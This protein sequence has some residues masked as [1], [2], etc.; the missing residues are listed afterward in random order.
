VKEVANT[1][2]IVQ[3]SDCLSLPHLFATRL[4]RQSYYVYPFAVSALE[5][6]SLWDQIYGLRDRIIAYLQAHPRAYRGAFSIWACLSP[7]WW[8]GV[9]SS[10]VWLYIGGCSQLGPFCRD[11]RL[12]PGCASIESAD[13]RED[14]ILLGVY[15]PTTQAMHLSMPV[16]LIFLPT[17]DNLDQRDAGPWALTGIR[18]TRVGAWLTDFTH[19]LLC[20]RTFRDREDIEGGIGD[21]V[22]IVFDRLSTPLIHKLGVLRERVDMGADLVQD[23]LKYGKCVADIERYLAQAELAYGDILV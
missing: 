17:Y 22:T 8:I 19:D 7:K 18:A 21:S 16:H 23:F 13:P 4:D 6:A 20:S 1:V 12:W 11:L 15:D 10:C 2:R 14:A 5:G 9:E 3:E